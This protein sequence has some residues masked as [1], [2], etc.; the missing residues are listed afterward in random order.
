MKIVRVPADPWG[1]GYDHLRLRS[2][3]AERWTAA[4]A[5]VHD[6]GGILTTSGGMRSLDAPVTAGRATY[7]LHCLGLAVDLYVHGMGMTTWPAP[8]WCEPMDL[9]KLQGRV[10]VWLCPHALGF[11][12]DRMEGARLVWSKGKI[13][14]DDGLWRCLPNESDAPANLTDLLRDHGLHSIGPRKG[15]P[16]KYGC[17]EAWHM[18]A[19]DLIPQGASFLDMARMI[20]AT[21]KAVLATRPKAG[22]ARWDGTRFEEAA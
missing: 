21:K 12:I 10:T 3:V 19:R 4:L 11:P 6:L 8:Y 2:D 15:W 17:S 7:S 5:H 16:K 9:E 22:C 18:E 14:A 13:S 20:G 1:E